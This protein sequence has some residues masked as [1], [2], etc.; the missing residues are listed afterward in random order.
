M[1]WIG[2]LGPLGAALVGVM[3]VNYEMETPALSDILAADVA[4]AAAFAAL[5]LFVAVAV[6]TSV[7]PVL[8][9]MAAPGPVGAS[10]ERAKAWLARHHRPILMVTFAAIGVYYTFR[11]VAGLLR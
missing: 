11:G 10:L 1:R 7:V 5:A 9:Y 8:G 4:R 2:R 6:S 3:L